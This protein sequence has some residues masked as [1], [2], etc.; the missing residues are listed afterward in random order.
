MH[1]TYAAIYKLLGCGQFRGFWALRLARVCVLQL[2]TVRRVYH[3]LATDAKTA[4]DWIDKIQLR[5]QWLA[6]TSR[7]RQQPPQHY[8]MSSSALCRIIVRDRPD[9]QDLD[10]LSVTAF[11]SCYCLSSAALYVIRCCHLSGV[12]CLQ[13]ELVMWRSWSKFAFVKCKSPLQ[14]SF[15]YECK[16]HFA[17]L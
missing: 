4:H 16:C 6:L 8:H 11:I 5:I 3:L 1:S 10:K 17:G 14:N 12:L 13:S 15:E 7:R 2:R 9:Q